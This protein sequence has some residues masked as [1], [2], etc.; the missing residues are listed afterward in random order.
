[1]LNSYCQF[2]VFVS[3]FARDIST[4]F[5]FSVLRIHFLHALLR[6]AQFVAFFLICRISFLNLHIFVADEDEAAVALDFG[7]RDE[8]FV[9]T[10]KGL[11]RA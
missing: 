1:M 10:A 2:L 9:Q 5:V 7:E 6:F 11:C 8:G 4:F 3:H